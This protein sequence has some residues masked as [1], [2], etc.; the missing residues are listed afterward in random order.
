MSLSDA[1]VEDELFMLWM[2]E[3]FLGF[4]EEI[5]APLLP[6]SFSSSSSSSSVLEEESSSPSFFFRP[7]M[8]QF[9]NFRECSTL[10]TNFE[11]ES[12]FPGSL[13]HPLLFSTPVMQKAAAAAPLLPLLRLLKA[14]KGPLL[15]R[16]TFR[17]CVDLI[18]W[19]SQQM[20]WMILPHA[21][22]V[23]TLLAS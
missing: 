23:I 8:F 3:S 14:L 19:P 10:S 20:K 1:T 12:A 22:E 2:P 16:S 6:L 18:Q 5:I 11:T 17:P 7:L 13:V 9:C 15:G 21:L 4:F